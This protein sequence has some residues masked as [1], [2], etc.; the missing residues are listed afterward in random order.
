MGSNDLRGVL[1]KSIDFTGFDFTVDRSRILSSE[2][3]DGSLTIRM[4]G[5]NRKT[6]NHEVVFIPYFKKNKL[7]F[8]SV[9]IGKSKNKKVK[10]PIVV[11]DQ[12]NLAKESAEIR[13]YGKMSGIVN[14][15]GHALK[16]LDIF[17]I[18]V[19]KKV[20]EVIK[21]FFR[22]QPTVAK[23]NKLNY[24]ICTLSVVKIIKD[25]NDKGIPRAPRVKRALR[26]KKESK[27]TDKKGSISQLPAPT[28]IIL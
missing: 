5:E 10:E 18:A 27:T 28:G 8:K 15:K 21:V 12:F 23:G 24:R 16:I 6:A 11:F 22:L 9:A 3:Y 13:K 17:N 19:P 4:P 7:K 26:N 20:N 2:I 14:S 1:T 25:E